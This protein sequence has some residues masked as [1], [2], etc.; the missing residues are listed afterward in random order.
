MAT[1]PTV[2]T[3]PWIAGV[4]LRHPDGMLWSIERP[5]RHSDVIRQMSNAGFGPD[6]VSACTQGFITSE[7]RFVTR[8][9]AVR[10][11]DQAGQIVQRTAPAHGLFSEDMW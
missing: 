2:T 10:I 3:L 7:G 1:D 6:V 8:H 4:A 9:A 11:A 5:Y